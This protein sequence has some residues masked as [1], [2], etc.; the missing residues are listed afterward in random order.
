MYEVITYQEIWFAAARQGIMT[1]QA[2]QRD[3]D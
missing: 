3:A 2:D 1:D